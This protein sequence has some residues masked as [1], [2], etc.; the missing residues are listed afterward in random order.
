ML[1][2]YSLQMCVLAF[3]GGELQLFLWGEPLAH[4]HNDP[5]L[6]Y[7]LT[8]IIS[9]QSQFVELTNKSK[10]NITTC[11]SS[12]SY[13]NFRN[14]ETSPVVPLEVLQERVLKI[15]LPSWFT[16]AGAGLSIFVGVNFPGVVLSQW[17]EVK[18]PWQ[19]TVRDIRVTVIQESRRLSLRSANGFSTQWAKL[20]R[21]IAARKNSS[22]PSATV[23]SSAHR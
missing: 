17:A 12:C 5:N 15:L 2:L 21:F 11:S 14:S 23:P 13:W 3:V 6:A 10:N 18:M 4:S 20:R 16:S 8:H 7:L 19:N 1:L 22:S 9:S